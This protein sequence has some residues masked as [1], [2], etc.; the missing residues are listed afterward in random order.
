MDILSVLFSQQRRRIGI[1]VPSVVITEKHSDTLEITDNPVDKPTESGAGFI[2]DHAYRRP[3]ELTMEL[4]F[5]GGG[6]LIDG[7]DTTAIFDASTGLSLGTSPAD[8]YKQILELQRDRKPFDAT[9][10]KRQYKNML[11]RAI[12][13]TTDKTSENVLMCVLT[14]KEIVITQ[15]QTITVADKENMKEG[16]NTSP[17]QN[18][19]TKTPVAVNESLLSQGSRLRQKAE[20]IFSRGVQ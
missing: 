19:G 20:E 10:G 4:G 11:I 6:S 15:T 2:A 9:T 16:L 3:S 18:T 14:L 17:V 12:E 7:V 5:A 1:I 8:I 13:V